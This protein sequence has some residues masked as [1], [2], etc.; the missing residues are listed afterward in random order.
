MKRGELYR[1]YKGSAEDPKK[2]RVFVVVSRQLLIDSRFSTVI[3]A[4][5]YSVH[6]GFSTQV[7]I[8]VDEGLKH[9]SSI[10]CDELVSIPKG[11]LTDY[12]GSLSSA[13]IKLLDTA[14]KAALELS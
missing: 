12:V 14:L 11:K 6:D 3:C 1:V 8:G 7:E 2:S 9:T 10:H 4:P 5:V 13:K